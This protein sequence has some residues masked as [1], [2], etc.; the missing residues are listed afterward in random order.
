MYIKKISVTNFRGLAS[1]KTTLHPGINLIVGGNGSGKTSFLSA[2]ATALSPIVQRAAG[3]FFRGR[4]IDLREVHHRTEMLAGRPKSRY[5]FPAVC[6]AEIVQEKNEETLMVIKASEGAEV[7]SWLYGQPLSVRR[8]R[9]V[10]GPLL[11]FYT[12]DCGNSL[13]LSSVEDHDGYALWYE[14]SLWEKDL[15]EWLI[16]ETCQHLLRD[17]TPD[18]GKNDGRQFFEALL[19]LVM[20]EGVEGAECYEPRRHVLIRQNKK[21]QFLNDMSRSDR[22]VVRLAAD[23]VQR[24]ERLKHSLTADFS[25]TEGVVLI[26]DADQWLSTSRLQRLL[27]GLSAAFPKVQ[28]IVSVREPL[29]SDGETPA[30][31]KTMSVLK[32]EN[33]PENSL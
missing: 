19:S 2:I 29:W 22:F 26:D 15:S 33:A 17:G 23:L 8:K 25:G 18:S 21:R 24:V 27:T 5:A 4:P 3:E 28:F 7:A 31:Q 9:S 12:E 13:D 6:C 14:S 30:I 20:S 16:D 10:R 1:L 32:A 11:A